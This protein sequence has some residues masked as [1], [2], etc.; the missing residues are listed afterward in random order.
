MK[1]YT[2]KSSLTVTI[3]GIVGATAAVLTLVWTGQGE[4][5]MVVPTPVETVTAPPVELAIT[6]VEELEEFL[7]FDLNQYDFLTTQQTGTFMNLGNSRFLSGTGAT[8]W[9]GEEQG[10]LWLTGRHNNW[11]SID[12]QFAPLSLVS[13][14]TYRFMAKGVVTGGAGTGMSIGWHRSEA[15]W[16]FMPGALGQVGADGTWKTDITLS[17]VLLADALQ[18][19]NGLRLQTSGEG[20]NVAD[21]EIHT[22][23]VYQMGEIPE[24]ME[25]F[26]AGWD[27]SVPSLHEAFAPFF[28]IGNIYPSTV[29]MDQFNTREMFAHHFNAVTAENWHK[30]DHI[31]NTGFNI[32]TPAQFNFANA[33]TI[34]DWAIANDITLVGHTLVWHSQS[35]NWLFWESAGVPHTREQARANMHLYISTLANHF[36]NRGVIEA[37]YSWDVVNEVIASG[38]GTWVG[39]W[40]TQL[41]TDS[42]WFMAYA[43]G[44][45][46]AFGEHPSD[47]IY[48][49]FVFARYYFPTSIL[50]YNDY[51]EE[52]PAKREAIAQMVE[53]LNERW[54]HDEINNPEAVPMGQAY[55]GRLLIEVIGMQSHYHFPMGGWSTNFDQVRPAIER[56]VATGAGVSITELDIT[57][58]GFGG[59]AT[60][61]FTGYL[62][63]AYAQLQA[64]VFARLFGY[65]LEFADDIG[66]VSI[67][68]MADN[69]SWRSAGHPLLFDADFQA[70]PAV[71]AILALASEAR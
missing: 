11:E 64:E 38:G 6:E 1:K 9:Q 36:E 10:T 49:A 54:A 53:Q 24:G 41:R 66:R 20:G 70:K 51:N 12:L 67:W 43:N 31:V 34:V 21:F 69:Q 63:E 40:R 4:E 14:G 13:G 35:P 27:L 48:D 47:F 3:G 59:N 18:T 62:P 57:M 22:I 46:P 15:P 50:Y 33:D 26:E 52:I 29:V 2:T 71:A 32:P 44:Y 55:T 7:L 60:R 42:P 28:K 61:S 56:F 5:E 39:D 8:V 68:G 30:P 16:T 23:R 65:Y 45:D 17:G 58:G 25:A 19:M 37:F